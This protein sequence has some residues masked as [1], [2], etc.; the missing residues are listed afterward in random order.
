MHVMEGVEEAAFDIIIK[1][2]TTAAGGNTQ[3]VY[4]IGINEDDFNN[5]SPSRLVIKSRL[6]GIQG[7]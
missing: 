2:E 3:N 4:F 1:L 5:S 7:F 6:D